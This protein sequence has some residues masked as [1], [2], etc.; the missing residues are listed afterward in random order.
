MIISA[1]KYVEIRTSLIFYNDIARQG[2]SFLRRQTQVVWQSPGTSVHHDPSATVIAPSAFFVRGGCQN[3]FDPDR[4]HVLRKIPAISFRSAQNRN[5]LFVFAPGS[6]GHDRGSCNDGT[7][8]EKLTW[9]FSIIILSCYLHT[10]KHRPRQAQ[11][12]WYIF[13]IGSK[14]K[15]SFRFR[16]RLSWP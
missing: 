5:L 2:S 6:P 1:C 15:S 12:S 9:L 3:Q 11:N 8:R 14:P 13:P 7:L 16:S 10:Y 4:L